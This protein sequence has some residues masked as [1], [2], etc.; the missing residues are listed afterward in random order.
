[1]FTHAISIANFA[2]EGITDNDHLE[3]WRSIA[4][5]NEVLTHY[6]K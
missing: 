6:S 5:I 3:P 4:G 1:M 2:L